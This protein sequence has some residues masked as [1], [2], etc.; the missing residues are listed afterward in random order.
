MDGRIEWKFIV[1]DN[2]KYLQ[3]FSNGSMTRVLEINHESFF[4]NLSEVLFEV[5]ASDK[6][7]HVQNLDQIVMAKKLHE[8]N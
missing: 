6:N 2:E 1:P 3:V 5:I 7:L 4:K 8:Q